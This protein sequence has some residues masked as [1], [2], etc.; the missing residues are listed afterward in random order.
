M[1]IITDAISELMGADSTN[2]RDKLRPASFRGLPFAVIAE[3]TSHGRRVAV[4]DYPYRDTAWIEDMGRGMRKL[5]LRCFI[6]ENSLVYGGG[7]VILQRRALIDACEKNGPGM[8]IHPTLGELTVSIPENGLRIGGSLENGRAFEFSLTLFESGLKVFAVTQS[9]VASATTKTNYLKLVSTA[10][11]TTVARVRGEIRGITQAI[12]T[13]KGVVSF[14]T[15][16]VDST[17]SEVT[18]VSNTLK[19]T[20]GNDKYGRYSEGSA[21]ADGTDT[22]ALAKQTIAKSVMDREKISQSTAALNNEND[23]E[24]IIGQISSLVQLILN[25][26]GGVNDRLRSLEALAQAQDEGYQ[27][28]SADRAVADSINALIL[29]LCSAAMAAA[30]TESTPSSQDDAVDITDRVSR[31]LDVALLRAGDR[32]D[33][34]IYHA[35]LQLR[36]S[37]ISTMSVSSQG[38]ADLIDYQTPSPLPALTLANRLYQDAGRADELINSSSTPHPAFMPTSM[39][40]LRK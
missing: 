9:E 10:V 6:V 5:T 35:L 30:A 27:Q 22:T 7:D 14:W 1:A 29:V 39:R 24:A 36:E 38:L 12:K 8:L 28:S 3:E 13:V 37:F 25:T 19:S 23:I 15:G 18:N 32:G 40:V 26:P 21:E 4:H 34:D 31:Q 16:F 2:W 17:L 33:D 11:L 20:F